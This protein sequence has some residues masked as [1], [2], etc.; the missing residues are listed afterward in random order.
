MFYLYILGSQKD[1]DIYIGSTN[2][3]KKRF[4]E[5]NSGKV[6]STKSRIPFVLLYYEA[7]KIEEESRKRESSL[8]LRGQARVQLLKR[9]ESTLKL[10]RN[11][12]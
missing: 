5:H 12:N 4:K 10:F 9:I 2:N 8:K 11:E 1:K 3:L 6:F 7:Y